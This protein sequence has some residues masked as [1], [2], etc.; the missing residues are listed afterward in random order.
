MIETVQLTMITGAALLALVLPLLSFLIIGFW[1][2]QLPRKGDWIAV[3]F[4]F[5]SFVAS[6][7]CFINTWNQ[8]VHHF[9]INWLN[10]GIIKLSAG[11]SIDN[12]AA[13]MLVLVTFITTLV[14]IYSMEYM[15]GE[16]Y[17]HRYFSH[18]SLFLFSMLGVVLADSLLLIYI[19]W[20]LVGFSSYLLIG[21]WFDR[22]TA[23]AANKKAFIVNRIGDIAFFV[24]IMILLT[25]FRTLDLNILFG[26]E[27]SGGIVQ[28]SSTHI[29][30]IAGLCI[31]AGAVAK[32]AQFP[33]HVWLPDAMEGPTS[34]SSLI[35]AATMVAAGVYLTARVF[36]LFSPEALNVIAIIG[37]LTSFMAASIALTQN[38]LKKVL[39][40]STISQLGIMMAAMGIGAWP[41]ALFH[42]VTHA[43]F[44]CLLFLGA[45]SVIHQL[46]HVQHK[47]H[48]DFDP[49]DMR[50]MGG[51]KKD[52]P[53]TYAVFLVAGL[54]LSGL[55]LFS[56][57]LS[58]D[59]ILIEAWSSKLILVPVLLTLTT[60]FTS[61]YIF[62]LIFKVFWSENK[63]AGL[64][65]DLNVKPH[66]SGSLMT[67]TMIVLAVCSTFIIFSFNP[68][69][70]TH[71]WVI[72][73]LKTPVNPLNSPS[74]ALE[75]AEL[76][77]PIT[78]V[79]FSLAMIY[80]A[81]RAYVQQKATFLSEHN[82]FY[83]FS[84]N[85][86]YFDQL[87]AVLFV[88][89]LMRFAG[90]V[91][92]F[93]VKVVDGI[94]NGAANLVLGFSAII[95][96]IDRN[97][98]DGFVNGLA[99]L[100]GKIGNFFRGFQTGR[101]QNYMALGVLGLILIVVLSYIF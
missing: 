100:V 12:L 60:V 54:A 72:E 99:L 69:H 36:P 41:M 24:G 14:L 98:I 4:T 3:S 89:P 90:F 61:F 7:Y 46:H 92:W 76:W 68:M 43:F 74:V 20:E 42:L 11:I 27:G 2:N 1:G 8:K 57:Y 84:F 13:L 31:F 85:A 64:Y 63:L 95:D 77:V 38:D 33:L 22:D 93:D 65:P 75:T 50:L 19:F 23:A 9:S 29:N 80:L 51:L 86:W 83:K 97:I 62:R 79:L 10:T 25:Q 94:V 35:H 40:Y 44:K 34:V 32:S 88:Q 91:K 30:T 66:E 82:F 37:A 71:S 81:F 78:T 28:H 17:Y 58:K 16:R 48:L 53:I 18:L 45:G 59:L 56:G 87:Y 39:A 101:V 70:G 49:Q 96:W 21:F 73:G 5:I 6:S 67:G 26:V 52:M 47:H 15:K 55:P